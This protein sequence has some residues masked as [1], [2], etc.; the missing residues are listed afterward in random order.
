MSDKLGLSLRA[1]LIYVLNRGLIKDKLDIEFKLLLL[2]N[3]FE[4][5]NKEYFLVSDIERALYEIN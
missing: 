4:L 3:E 1:A 2:K 5:M